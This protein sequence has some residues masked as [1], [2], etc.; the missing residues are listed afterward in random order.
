MKKS[1][2]VSARS[3]SPKDAHK[4]DFSAKALALCL[5]GVKGVP[6]WISEKMS[7]FI[8]ADICATIWSV[9]LWSE[10]TLEKLLRGSWRW[11]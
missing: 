11:K 4:I 3:F 7:V 1:R 9:L 2:V 8:V 5:Q 6:R 10:L